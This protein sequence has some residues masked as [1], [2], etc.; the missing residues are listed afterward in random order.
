M[1]TKF[2]SKNSLIKGGI[3]LGSSLV[4]GGIFY[5]K[6]F[7][8]ND[9]EIELIPPKKI[10]LLANKLDSNSL[11]NLDEVITTNIH[12]DLHLNF[13]KQQIKGFLLF[14]FIIIFKSIF[15]IFLH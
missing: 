14:Y 9:E 5:Y 6:F 10:P 12:L 3:V 13:E 1:L 2:I 8:N 7:Q 4:L 11:S 15:L